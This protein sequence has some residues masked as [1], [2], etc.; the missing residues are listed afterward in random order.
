MFSWLFGNKKQPAKKRSTPA[1]LKK[2]PGPSREITQADLEPIPPRKEKDPRQLMDEMGG[3]E[4]L[5][6][7]IRSL[8]LEDKQKGN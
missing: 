5:A 8:L 3:P 2:R 7:V 1:K 6:Q 4:E